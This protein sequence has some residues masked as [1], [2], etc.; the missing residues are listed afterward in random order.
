MSQTKPNMLFLGNIEGQVEIWD[1]HD[2]VTKSSFRTS[3]C[4]NAVV[5][6][7]VSNGDKMKYLAVSD[8]KGFTRR[9]KLPSFLTQADMVHEKEWLQ[10]FIDT[11]LNKIQDYSACKIQNK[12][13]AK[14]NL[15]NNEVKKIESDENEA[16]S[17]FTKKVMDMKTEYNWTIDDH[18]K[19]IMK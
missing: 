1:L 11:Q 13:K 6:L 16:W 10:Q 14:K 9:V 17:Y 12:Q 7:S 19:E 2:Q 8:E 15:E 5:K 18:E 3:L 4:D